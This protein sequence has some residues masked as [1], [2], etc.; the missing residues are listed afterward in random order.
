MVV[1]R[2]RNHLPFPDCLLVD[3]SSDCDLMD[4]ANGSYMDCTDMKDEY[5]SDT[6]LIRSIQ[7][8]SCETDDQALGQVLGSDGSSCS[9]TC[10]PLR[11]RN[12]LFVLCPSTCPVSW[13]TYLFDPTCV[14]EL[15]IQHITQQLPPTHMR[16]VLLIFVEPVAI[17]LW[18]YEGDG[19]DA[20]FSSASRYCLL[21]KRE[22]ETDD[23]NETY[24]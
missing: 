18:E 1:I 17:A 19:Q 24:V 13:A 16:V 20:C 21:R 6:A 15:A 10:F 8:F 11:W 3:V 5:E 9:Y 14:N 12:E 22:K 2:S 7:P 4:E 23:K